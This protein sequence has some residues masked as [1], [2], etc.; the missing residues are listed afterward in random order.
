MQPFS[1]KRYLYS[2]AVAVVVVALAV[3]ATRFLTGP[4]TPDPEQA[5]PVL[6]AYLV[7]LASRDA[8]AISRLAPVGYDVAAD[9]EDRLARYGGVTNPGFS[10]EP[11]IAPKVVVAKIEATRQSTPVTWTENLVWRDDRWNV[12]LG[13]LA[14]ATRPG[15]S[16][17]I[18]DVPTS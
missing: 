9:V 16:S 15:P 17:A 12:L 14:D 6:T 5:S 4:S 13:N 11:G 8:G 10:L 1:R 7:A 3:I 2:S 18:T